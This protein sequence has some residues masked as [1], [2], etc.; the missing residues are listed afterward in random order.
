[1]TST[2]DLHILRCLPRE[3]PLH[4]LWAGTKLIIVA[5]V[6]IALVA[7][8][9]W[10]A[11]GVAAAFLLLGVFVARYPPGAVPRF[12]KWFFY[13]LG[14]GA[15]LSLVSGG[16]PNVTI[17]NMTIGLG[18][19]EDWARFTA[20]GVIVFGMAILLGATTAIADLPGAVDRLSTPLRWIRLPVDEFI[21]AFT[22]VVRA[23]PLI[24]DEMRA[25]YAAWRLRRPV[26]GKDFGVVRELHDALITAIAASMRRARDLAHAID[27]RGGIGRMP[28]PPMRLRIG[29]LIAVLLA[30]AAVFAIIRL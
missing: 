26:L 27:A 30:A 18:G 23:F 12:P 13:L 5:A 29:D 17:G 1:M 19:L 24:M 11:Q 28:P 21:A 16:K 3:S 22:L 25:L 8:P 6:G 7:K 4:R 20:L 10:P 14:F 15:F 9:T 2:T